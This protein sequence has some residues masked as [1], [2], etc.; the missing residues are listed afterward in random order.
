MNRDLSRYCYFIN[1]SGA[2]R[3]CQSLRYCLG[4]SRK[5]KNHDELI[6]YTGVVSK[7]AI[8]YRHAGSVLRVQYSFFSCLWAGSIF[9]KQ[10][11]TI[12]IRVQTVKSLII[13]KMA[14]SKSAWVK[15]QDKRIGQGRNLSRHQMIWL[16]N[17]TVKEPVERRGLQSR[18]KWV[19]LSL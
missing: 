14:V 19:F 5:S 17:K 15:S 8:F 13:M 12:F 4:S 6:N 10:L 16:S 9:W 1:S 2:V 11:I 18:Y 7:S 3:I